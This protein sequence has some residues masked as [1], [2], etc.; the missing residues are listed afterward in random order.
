MKN[1]FSVRVLS[2]VLTAI[3]VV[4]AFSTA[5][6]VLFASAAS[7]LTQLTPIES[8]KVTS[9]GGTETSVVDGNGV[10]NNSKVMNISASSEKTGII[11]GVSENATYDPNLGVY[12]TPFV[13]GSAVTFNS[14]TVSHKFKTTTSLTGEK[15]VTISGNYET[16]LDQL[17]ASQAY[18][19]VMYSDFKNSLVGADG[20]MFYLKSDGANTFFFDFALQMPENKSRWFKIK[21]YS[22]IGYNPIMLLGVGKEYQYMSIGGSSWTTATAIQ[23]NSGNTWNGGIKF[24]SAFEGY[25]KIPI[26]SLVN[27]SGFSMNLNYDSFYQMTVHALGLGGKYGSTVTAGPFFAVNND[28][29]LGKF[30]VSSTSPEA[31]HDVGGVMEDFSVDCENVEGIMLY[32]KT[33]SANRLSVKASFKDDYLAEVPDLQLDTGTTVYALRKGGNKWET[34]KTITTEREGAIVL[35]SAFEGYIKIPFESMASN[36]VSAS[37]PAVLPEISDL[38]AIKVYAAGIGGGYGSV[39]AAPFLITKNT[40]STSFALTDGWKPY[41]P[42]SEPMEATTITGGEIV[43]WQSATVTPSKV[44][45]LKDLTSAEG[46]KLTSSKGEITTAS[47]GSIV[48]NKV[49]AQYNFKTEPNSAT[50]DY[51]TLPDNYKTD[52]VI[53]FYVKTN[54]ANKIL[55]QLHLKGNHN[56]NYLESNTLKLGSTYS[57]AAIGDDTWTEATVKTSG[58][59][60]SGRTNIFGLIEFDEAF[61]GYVKIPFTSLATIGNAATKQYLGRIEF[62]FANIGGNHGEVTVGSFFYVDKDSNSTVIKLP[63][64]TPV[65]VT[66]ITGG[67]LLNYY[68][69]TVTPQIVNPLEKFNTAD[70]IK[71]TASKGEVTTTVASGVS[72]SK[73]NAQYEFKESPNATT[74]EFY[75]LPDSYKTQGAFIV[76]VKTNGANKILPQFELQGNAT[77]YLESNTL[78]LGSTYSYA[79]IGANKWTEATV[80]NSGTTTS[81]RTDI[82][83][84]IEFDE[85][86]EGYIKIPFTSLATIG[87]AATKQYLGKISIAFANIGG[88]HGEIT[89]GPFFYVDKDS[90]STKLKL[91]G[92]VDEDAPKVT[93]E[94]TSGNTYDKI[95]WIFENSKSGAQQ[96]YYFMVG[97]STRHQLGFPVFRLVRHELAERYN[98]ISSVQAL[99]GLKTEHWS[100]YTPGLQGSNPTVEELITKI[101]AANETG[102]GCIVDIALGINDCFGA[103]KADKVTTYVKMGIDKIRAACP[104]AV[105]VYTSP[106]ILQDTTG[107]KN[108]RQA[109]ANIWSDSSIYAIDTLD[110]VFSQFFTAYFVDT[111]HP[112]IDGYRQIAK[113]ILSKYCSDITFEKITKVEIEP[114]GDLTIPSGATLITSG[115]SVTKTLGLTTSNIG[116]NTAQGLAEAIEIVGSASFSG[117][118]PFNTLNFVETHLSEPLNGYDYIAFHIDIPSANRMGLTAFTDDDT[119]ECIFKNYSKYYIMADGTSNWVTKKAT[120]GRVDGSDTYGA[121]QFDGAFSGWIKVPLSGF[122]G[123]PTNSEDINKITMRFSELGGSYGKIRVGAF[124]GINDEP[125]VAKNVWKKSNLPEMTPFTP[126]T[127]FAGYTELSFS[128]IPSPIPTLTSNKALKISSS[129]GVDTDSYLHYYWARQVYDKMPIG[130]FSHIMIYVKVPEGKDNLLTICMFTD[131]DYEFKTQANVDYALL[132]LGSNEWDHALFEKYKNQWGGIRIPAGFEGFLKIPIN[133]FWPANQVKSDTVLCRMEYRFS[134]IGSDENSVLVGPVFGVTKDNDAG[135]GDMVYTELPAATTIKSLYAPDKGDIYTDSIMLYWEKYNDAAAYL[136]EAYSITKTETGF[137]YRLAASHKVFSNSG[138]VTGLMPDREYAILVKALDKYDNVIAIYDYTVVKTLNEELYKSPIAS[139]KMTYNKVYYPVKQTVSDT[140]NSLTIVIVCVGSVIALLAALAVVVLLIVKKRRKKNN[141]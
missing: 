82:F 92:S 87:N 75:K 97:D 20:I 17:K 36:S 103:G 60:T 47:A 43:N 101:K 39:Q 51:Y 12:V 62:N 54:G 137:E 110:G 107:T 7:D 91:T 112:N 90:E 46:I 28:S 13:G 117:K 68:S 120:D 30:Q 8:F 52:G 26:S 79:A 24:D 141:A 29:S 53:M 11:A 67:K 108:L 38:T 48:T 72:S 84:L 99:S 139:D 44:T 9:A 104:D 69:G 113:Y 66:P 140:G 81:G 125:Y 85:A 3:F 33:D 116:Y 18:A 1:K 35:D 58:T 83:G 57:Y 64:P 96:G 10:F 118:N 95:Q 102:K 138:A 78:K 111:V 136:I 73:I 65:E 124:I 41:D 94:P 100:G 45:P 115:L 135:P 122:Y 50:G 32:V 105:I 74:G 98:I 126:V 106:N 19:A 119:T 59:T 130:D 6:P 109:A 121:I 127:D 89:V 133:N 80:T 15:G 55:P 49:V 134:F 132:A 88:K 129:K 22:A 4:T 93:E 16:T 34:L 5:L 2:I 31:P 76:Y 114:V 23:C 70:A 63:D 37:Y 14:A 42:S 71:L 123:G 131:T 27:D 56:Y 86:F 25:I 77:S 21:D 40:D 61:E 128:M